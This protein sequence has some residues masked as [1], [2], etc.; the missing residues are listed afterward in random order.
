MKNLKNKMTKLNIYKWVSIT[1]F[2]FISIPTA[3]LLLYFK[4]KY[5]DEII[6]T[7]GGISLI[8]FIHYDYIFIKFSKT[9]YHDASAAYESLLKEKMGNIKIITE[10]KSALQLQWTKYSKNALF[11]VKVDQDN[12]NIYFP[13]YFKS[14][15]AWSISASVYWK[16]EDEVG[17][18]RIDGNFK[19]N[20]FDNIGNMETYLEQV[21]KI[22]AEI[23]Y[24][25]KNSIII[26]KNGEIQNK[27]F[28]KWIF[29]E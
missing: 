20:E 28:P 11:Y 21:N 7:V 10:N 24:H 6:Y 1:L 22:N 19:W 3:I 14:R 17:M 15:D 8:P 27:D 2:V 25:V 23:N 5:S 9:F 29:I 13:I 4:V 18:F 12:I 26:L 16:S